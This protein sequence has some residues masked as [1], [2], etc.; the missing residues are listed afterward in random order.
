MKMKLFIASSALIMAL[1]PTV[2]L[3]NLFSAWGK[4]NNID[5][6]INS[7]PSSQPSPIRERVDL[8]NLSVSPMGLGSL[9]LPLDKEE[10]EETTEVMKVAKEC[11]VNLVDT[12]EA[13][14]FGK[15]ESLLKSAC[16]GAGLSIGTDNDSNVIAA[17]TK[18]APVPWRTESQKVVEACMASASRLGVE[19]IPLYQIHWPDL[20]QPLKAFGRE[21]R[22]DE[23]YWE[24]LAECYNSGLAANVGVSNYGPETIL[25]AQEALSKKGVTIASNQINFSLMQYRSSEKTLQVC[26]DLGIKVLSYFPLANGLLAG[27][28]VLFVL[29]FPRLILKYFLLF[30]SSYALILVI[31]LNIFRQ[32]N[33]PWTPL[34]LFPRV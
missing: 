3:Q 30:V 24:G 29:L 25:R 11:G 26:E 9:N 1:E 13:Y 23:L 27:A 10:D 4:Q 12:A 19:Q 16:Q 5:N 17:A 28:W 31:M 6:D 20:I 33:I 15:S 2:A 7:I 32:A 8:G 22:K 14:G 18:F 34:L 21:N